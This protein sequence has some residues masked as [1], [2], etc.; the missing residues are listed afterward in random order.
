M[1]IAQD[2]ITCSQQEKIYKKELGEGRERYIY[3]VIEGKI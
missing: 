2:V 3:V 1:C